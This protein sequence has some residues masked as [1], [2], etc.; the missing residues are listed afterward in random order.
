MKLDKITLPSGGWVEFR[1]PSDMTGSEYR[2]LQAAIG[3]AV[4]YGAVYAATLPILAEILISGWECKD[5]REGGRKLP[6]AEPELLDQVKVN[7][8]MAIDEA[9]RPVAVRLANRDRLDD[10]DP[11][12]PQPPASD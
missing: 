9:L 2:R 12:T 3:G 7:D 8:L 11:Q 5:V 1:D 6:V 4:N 10:L